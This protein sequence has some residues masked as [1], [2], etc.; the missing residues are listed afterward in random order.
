MDVRGE[1]TGRVFWEFEKE[2][3]A[4]GRFRAGVSRF[5]RSFLEKGRRKVLLLVIRSE[6]FIYFI[7]LSYRRE[8]LSRFKGVNRLF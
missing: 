8:S 4:Y 1:S 6:E 7:R 3:L 2:R 5:W